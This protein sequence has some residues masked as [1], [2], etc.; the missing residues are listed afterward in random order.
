MPWFGDT[1]MFL[2]KYGCLFPGATRS[3]PPGW[4]GMRTH[5]KKRV[6]AALMARGSYASQVANA[7]VTNCCGVAHPHGTAPFLVLM[8]LAS[9]PIAFPQPQLRTRIHS[10][11]TGE[12]MCQAHIPKRPRCTWLSRG[13]RQVMG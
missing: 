7:T 11:V 9:P 13:W 2:L 5:T 8:A 3:I 6:L 4:D 1:G 12:S 10:N